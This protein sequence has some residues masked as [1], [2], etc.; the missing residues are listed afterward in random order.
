M[1][2]EA[3]TLAEPE[4]D[5]VLVPLPEGV[6]EAL[7]HRDGEGVATPLTEPLELA[8]AGGE[9]LGHAEGDGDT[10]AVPDTH[11]ES[12]GL[13]VLEEEAEAHC[14]PCELS[15]PDTVAE[16]KPLGEGIGEALLAA[17]GDGA[18]VPLAHALGVAVAHGAGVGDAAAGAEAAVEG[19]TVTVPDA[20]SEAMGLAVRAMVAVWQPLGEA[21][22][23]ALPNAVCEAGRVSLAHALGEAVACGDGESD[24]EPQT[25]R[26]GE[27]EMQ[28]L[29][30]A[31]KEALAA[32]DCD[33]ST[34]AEGDRLELGHADWDAVLEVDEDCEVVDEGEGVAVCDG[35][36]RALVVDTG[37]SVTHFPSA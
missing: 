33:E 30:D 12:V 28:L 24:A 9:A 21:L 25:E 20:H 3:L 15:V 2:G 29:G 6:S 13:A 35:E 5:A 16:R 18:S 31:A 10:V 7:L 17:V 8:V 23:E 11:C 4:A 36:A 22:G 19:D 34:V 32:S 26:E 14:E 27:P 37:S 1:L